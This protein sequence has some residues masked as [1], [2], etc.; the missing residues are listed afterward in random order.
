MGQRHLKIPLVHSGRQ[1]GL[2]PAFL[3]TLS[4]RSPETLGQGDRGLAHLGLLEWRR[5][6]P[7]STGISPI[8][9][10]SLKIYTVN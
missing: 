10:Q 1:G 9:N 6:Q 5:P 2:G 7:L 8:Y 3:R 4:A